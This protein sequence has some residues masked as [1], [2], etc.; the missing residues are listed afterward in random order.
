[1]WFNRGIS[2]ARCLVDQESGLM[3][4]DRILLERFKKGSS[5]ALRGIYE[6]YGNYLLTLASALLGDCSGAEDV[7]HDVFCK[8]I[9]CRERIKVKGNLKGY[10]GTCVA[11]LARDR[12]RSRGRVAVG[13]D[14][15]E[16]IVS[17]TDGPVEAVMWGEEVRELACALAELP[18][19]QREVVVLHVRGAMRFREIAEM[20]GE[21]INTIKSRYRYGLEKLRSLLV[22]SC[23][24]TE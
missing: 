14:A 23:K 20:Q 16:A 12:I 22:K 17:D 13:C 9:Q 4:E 1:M 5:D 8:F 21:S 10:L 2:S 24:V 6:K 3:L 18:Y 19:E 7:V 11:N 15:M